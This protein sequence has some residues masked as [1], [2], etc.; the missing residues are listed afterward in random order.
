M[1]TETITYDEVGEFLALAAAR[2]Q[3]TVGDADILA[4]YSDLNAARVNA[5]A[6]Q[7]AL[8]HYYAVIAPKFDPERRHRINAPDLLAIIRKARAD[9]LGTGALVDDGD[10]DE[11]PEQFLARKRATEQ[12]VADGRIAPPPALAAIGPAPANGPQDLAEDDIRA[13]RQ[14]KD[15]ARFMRDGMAAGR[16]ACDARKRLVLQHDDLAQQLTQKP[17]ALARPDCWNGFLPPE[18]TESGARNRSPVRAQLAALVTEAER[19]AA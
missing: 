5:R 6:A 18:H 7:A 1:T 2:D 8:T 14:Q 19:R 16:A 9:R 4:W 11:T 15:L 3:R 12:A 17:I 13:L 10:P